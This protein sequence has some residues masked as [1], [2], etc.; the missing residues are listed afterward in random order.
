[1]KDIIIPALRANLGD[2]VYYSATIPLGILSELVDFADTLHKSKEL[3]KLI[4]REIKRKRGVEISD[5]LI[6]EKEHF[7][8][9]LVVAVYG[10]VPSWH[11]IEITSSHSTISTDNLTESQLDSFGFLRFTGEESLFAVDGQHRLAGIKKA[12]DSGHKFIDE[13]V[14]VLFVAHQNTGAG[15]ERTR[16]L[17]TTLNKTAV[18]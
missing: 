18:M 11:S 7:F 14:S 4:Q 12:V 1:M 9:S 13:E 6:R 5:Y 15:I 3:S 10:G 16:R 8:N 2:W 17:F